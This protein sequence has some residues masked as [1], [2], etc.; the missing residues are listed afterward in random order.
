MDMADILFHTNAD[1]SAKE[2][3]E[4]EA[5]LQGCEGMISAH[6]SGEH[7]HLLKVVYDPAAINS[8]VVLTHVNDHGAEA[9]KIGF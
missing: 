6:F 7:P 2:R 3:E 1:L 5:D 4:I 8:D 9:H